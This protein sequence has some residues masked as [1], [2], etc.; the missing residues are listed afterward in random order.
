MMNYHTG[1]SDTAMDGEEVAYSPMG[2]GLEDSE[3]TIQV[4]IARYRIRRHFL[5]LTSLFSFHFSL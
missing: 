3:T 5:L 2:A 4:G 1:F